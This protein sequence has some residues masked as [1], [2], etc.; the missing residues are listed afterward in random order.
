MAILLLAVQ[1]NPKKAKRI[2]QQIRE[3]DKSVVRYMGKLH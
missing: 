1:N 3:Y 2:I